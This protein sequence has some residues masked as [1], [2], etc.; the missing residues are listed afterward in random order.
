[1]VGNNGSKQIHVEN[2]WV[3]NTV[4]INVICTVKQIP[5]NLRCFT[6]QPGCQVKHSKFY[7]GSFTNCAV[8]LCRTIVLGIC[9]VP[10][11][12]LCR[13]V[14]SLLEINLRLTYYVRYLIKQLRLK[15]PQDAAST[16][17]LVC[18]CWG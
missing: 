12:M 8:Q 3:Y 6:W 5:Y 2:V 7:G 13:T 17:G 14:F 15:L 4:L 18:R 1:M 16:T 9:V 10:G 11:K